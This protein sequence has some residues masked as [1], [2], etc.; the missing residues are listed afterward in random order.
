[1]ERIIKVRLAAVAMIAVLCGRLFYI[2]VCKGESLATRAV[3]QRT[4]NIPLRSVRGIIYDRNMLPLTEGQSRLCAAVIPSECADLEEVERL[5]GHRIEGGEIRIFELNAITEEQ[6][7]LVKMRGVRLFNVSERY[8]ASGILS[9][10]IG[11]TS[12]EGGFGIERVFNDKLTAKQADSIS[13]I[14]NAGSGILSGLGFKKTTERTY[15][16]VKLSI[17]YHIQKIV[18]NAM[19][20]GVKS[21]AAV[22]VDTKTGDIVAMASRPN[23]KQ[24][25]LVKYLSS[26]EGELVNRAIMPYDVG[27]VF[28]VVLV[29]AALDEG[30]YAPHSDFVCNG[31]IDVSGKEFVCNDKDGH[32]RI[33][34]EGGLAHSCNVVFYTIG[35]RLGIDIISKYAKEFGFGDRVL[36]IDALGESAGFIP[37]DPNSPPAAVANISIGQGTV[38]VTPLQ[39]AD[40]LCTIANGGIRRQLTLVKGMVDDSGASRDVSPA[41]VGRVI[42]SETA[43][44]LKNMLI[45]AVDYGTGT[46]AKIEGWQ[47]AGKTG[48][49]QTGWLKNGEI[50]THGWFGGFF[51]A[52]DPQ[53]VCVVLCENGKSGATSAAPVFREIGEGIK[54]LGIDYSYQRSN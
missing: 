35:G 5:T 22:V 33:S 53:Y 38:S 13:M 23:F 41:D 49:A 16:G 1:M 25:E 45:A 4:E 30:V 19:D 15:K 17:D 42:S 54:A 9:H 40:M 28:K 6:A 31:S 11:Y 7:R 8:N 12:D 47:T 27:S 29:A 2:S 51:P 20:K 34:L 21:G 50:M 24:S 44:I 46:A 18:E 48:S 32:G 26:T 39:V 52:D 37:T 3:I 14:T 10:V 43:K 36:K